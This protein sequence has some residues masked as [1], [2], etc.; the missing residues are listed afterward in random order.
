MNNYIRPTR[1]E[2]K[3]IE[4]KE[5]LLNQFKNLTDSDLQFEAG[6]KYAMISRVSEKLG[7]P[8]EEMTRIFQKF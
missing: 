8:E 3:W 4:Q 6:R 1:S 2:E 5:K 7:I